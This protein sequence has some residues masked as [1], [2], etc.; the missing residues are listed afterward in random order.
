MKDEKGIQ[1]IGY[2]CGMNNIYRRRLFGF[3]LGEMKLAQK[4]AHF[5]V[6]VITGENITR[7]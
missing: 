1:K 6:R 3:G 2:D 4:N 7:Y 5:P